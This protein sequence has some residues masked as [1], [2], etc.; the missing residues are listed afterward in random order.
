MDLYKILDINIIGTKIP[1]VSSTCVKCK[2]H[3]CAMIDKKDN[4][5]DI[6]FYSLPCGHGVHI[7]CCKSLIVCPIDGKKVK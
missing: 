5:T 4:I 6:T 7:N 3:L 1:V 2:K